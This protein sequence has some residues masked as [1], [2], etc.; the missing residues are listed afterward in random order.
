MQNPTRAGAT[1]DRG[2]SPL[3]FLY[4][5]GAHFV[6]CRGKKPFWRAW[7]RR[8]P[9]LDLVLAHTEELGLIPA[10]VGTSA[11]D[12]D[13]GEI[14]TLVVE[15][16][17]LTLCP[18]P[19]GHHAYYH[20]DEGRGNRIFE[21]HGCR[22]HIRSAKGYLRLYPSGP[23]RLAH[24]LATTDAGV[25]R[26]PRDLFELH[27][28]EM[29]EQPAPARAPGTMG[30]FDARAR[31][32]ALE[33]IHP[34]ARNCALFDVVRF[35]AYEETRGQDLAAWN[36]RVLAYA[37]AQNGR[38]PVPLPGDEVGWTAY[39]ISTW[40]W[41][42]GGKRDHSTEA[43]RR[44]ILKRWHSDAMPSTLSAIRERD[45]AIV[46]AVRMDG[47]SMRNVANQHALSARA[48]HYIVHRDAPLL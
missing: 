10:S 32:F 18:T 1:P 23:E 42:G 6:L 16:P 30:P 44:R 40:C 19:R 8:R 25:G 34:G 2:D 33:E 46:R 14:G 28:L 35:W 20:D 9:G 41:A 38:F 39:S 29:P 22:G 36:A 26:F 47:R 37:L 24:A 48:I 27:G 45:A 5:R 17:P 7:N 43:Q 3:A 15:W 13:T 21:S 12:V 11:L 4:R 31:A